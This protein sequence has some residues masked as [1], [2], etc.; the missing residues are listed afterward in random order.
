MTAA[1]VQ[2]AARRPASGIAIDPEQLTRMRDMVPL[3]REDLAEQAG[4]LLFDYARFARV[5]DGSLQPD[6]ATARVLWLAL[7]RAPGEI[8]RRLPPGLPRNKVPRWL[9]ANWDAW[10][11][12]LTAVDQWRT[13]LGWSRDDL[14]HAAAQYGFSRDSVNKIERG[15]RRPKARTLRAFCQILGCKPVDLMP[16]SR[17]LPEGET[18]AR[19]ALIEFNKGM[20]E[21]ADAQDPPLSYRT[22][23]GRINYDSTGV[24]EAYGE[25]LTGQDGRELIM[26]QVRE[27]VDRQMQERE[28]S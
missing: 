8:I 2:P 5:L 12:D 22:P 21:W 16:G 6:A 10:S 4:M 11:L 13:A 9:R 7:G 3:S 28:A 25:Y 23:G 17:E 24:R 15:E 1:T 14:A 18:A 26:P 20:R 27:A 19:A